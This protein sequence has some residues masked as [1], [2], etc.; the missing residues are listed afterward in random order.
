MYKK[1]ALTFVIHGIP[2]GY[3]FAFAK[4]LGLDYENIFKT[5]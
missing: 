3:Q 2:I 1:Y 5:A 4:S